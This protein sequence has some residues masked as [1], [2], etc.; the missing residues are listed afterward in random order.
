[1]NPKDRARAASKDRKA[2]AVKAAAEKA[3]AARTTAEKAGTKTGQHD[4]T[5]VSMEDGDAPP[6]RRCP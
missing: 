5:A 3:A 1:M 2:A 4:N 6:L